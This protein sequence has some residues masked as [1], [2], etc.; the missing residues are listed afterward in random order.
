MDSGV[1]YGL[2]SPCRIA[3]VHVSRADQLGLKNQWGS[4]SLEK[5]DFISLSSY[6]TT[7][8]LHLGWDHVK[9]PCPRW[10]VNWWYHYASLVQRTHCWNFMD[11]LIYVIPKGLQNLSAPSSAISPSLRCRGFLPV[12][13]VELR[14]SK[15]LFLY[16]IVSFLS[17]SLGLSF[18]FPIYLF[19]ICLFAY[20]FICL[21]VQ[22][23]FVCVTLAVLKPA[24]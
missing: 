17:L 16:F 18:S 13:S 23:E 5:T 19:V 12:I 15:S 8:V 20:L 2:L 1:K 3:S 21:A 7:I 11:A 24:L 6:W 9:F 4:A 22:E 10:W 14:T